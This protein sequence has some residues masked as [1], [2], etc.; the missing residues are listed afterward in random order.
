MPP[1]TKTSV[2]KY[3]DNS[4]NMCTTMPVGSTIVAMVAPKS[5]PKP[6]PRA[7]KAA[8]PKPSVAPVVLETPSQQFIK[9]RLRNQI[10]FG[11]M[12]N[13]PS[14][15]INIE[16]SVYNYA[17]NEA[18][19]NGIV[20]KPTHMPFVVL[21]T[22]R[23]LSVWRN[24]QLNPMLTEALRSEEITPIMMETMTHIELHMEKWKSELH[25]KNLRDQSRFTNNEVACTSAYVC[26]RCQSRRCTFCVV[27][28]RSS[29]EP[30][31]VFVTCLDCGKN[32]TE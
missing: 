5:K 19:K 7:K 10:T 13:N 6:K 27:Q 24:L 16:I 30:M 2:N 28:I 18:T 4:L 23:L 14:L 15:G 21:Y 25:A 8:A 26:R 12:F 31:T 3:K 32:F 22:S 20:R 1:R 29:D 17:I 11:D 9:Q